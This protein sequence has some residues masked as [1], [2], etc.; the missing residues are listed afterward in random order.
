MFMMIPISYAEHPDCAGKYS[1]EQGLYIVSEINGEV[2]LRPDLYQEFWGIDD[3][4]EP[5][6]RGNCTFWMIA[7]IWV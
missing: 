4:R 5:Q 3:L 6:N 7:W 2:E 1:S